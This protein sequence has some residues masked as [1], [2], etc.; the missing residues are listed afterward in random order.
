MEAQLV[1]FEDREFQDAVEADL[2]EGGDFTANALR[3][4]VL[5]E[6]IAGLRDE[7]SKVAEFTT[8]RMQ[9]VQ[10]HG[11]RELRKVQGR[12][13]WLEGVVR[14]LVP[15]TGHGM[16]Q[17]FGKKSLA[18]P[19]GSVGYRASPES[20]VV[21]DSTRALQWA[22]ERGLEVTV[23]ESVGKTA[24]HAYVKETG[25]EPDP[26]ECGFS[27][28]PAGERFYLKTEGES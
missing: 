15:S 23:R 9:M 20:I 7:E 8:R 5:L 1:P 10:A 11:E 22:K 3:V 12:I 24:L 25:D 13:R 21:T 2:P 28:E 18:L 26:K 6:K 19:H 16:Q 14:R 17:A 27:L 4:D